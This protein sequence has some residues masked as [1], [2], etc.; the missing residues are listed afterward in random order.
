MLG[1]G[2]GG[3]SHSCARIS[4]EARLRSNGH[5]SCEICCRHGAH[6]TVISG[7]KQRERI[8]GKGAEKSCFGVIGFIGLIRF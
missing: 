1:E 5:G 6:E 7:R 8:E 4:W 2:Q 3:S